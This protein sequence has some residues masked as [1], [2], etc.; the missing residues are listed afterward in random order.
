M[1]GHDK[2][3][4]KFAWRDGLW[5][6]TRL[7]QSAKMLVLSDQKVGSRRYRTVGEDIVIG[8]SGNDIEMKRRCDAQKI[9]FGQFGQIH[10]PRQ[11]PPSR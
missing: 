2:S 7:P 3:C 5:F 4:D 11:F 10:E 8:V 1:S 6:V 9:P